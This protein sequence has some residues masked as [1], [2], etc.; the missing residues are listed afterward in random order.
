MNNE[1][2]REGYDFSFN[3]QGC[4]SCGGECCLGESG[5]VWIT[6]AEIKQLSRFLNISFRECCNDYLTKEKHRYTINE[7]K[8]SEN[9]YACVFFDRELK[10]C[11]VYDARPTQCRTFP[12]WED[13]QL[14]KDET[15]HMCPAVKPLQIS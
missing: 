1:I 9:A 7:I 5:F 15:Y 2:S 14:V 4:E 10:K 12:F 6:T 13:Y 11:S 3:P 8:L